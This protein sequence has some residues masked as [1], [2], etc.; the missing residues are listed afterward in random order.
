M[1]SLICNYDDDV[2]MWCGT[3]RYKKIVIVQESMDENIKKHTFDSESQSDIYRDGR[4]DKPHRISI[5]R[6]KKKE[7]WQYSPS[8]LIF[9]DRSFWFL[10]WCCYRIRE[11]AQFFLDPVWS[12]QIISSTFSNGVALFKA[13]INL[14]KA[15]YQLLF[16]SSN[17]IDLSVQWNCNTVFFCFCDV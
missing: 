1:S 5:R 9:S 17:S 16:T 7:K 3:E 8:A 13:A 14:A 6:S 4:N 12:C 15:N 11:I 10:F 2:I